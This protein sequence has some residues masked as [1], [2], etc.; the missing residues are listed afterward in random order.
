[1]F[2]QFKRPRDLAIYSV[3]VLAAFGIGGAVF[4]LAGQKFVHWV[5]T[6]KLPEIQRLTQ[7]QF[8]HNESPLSGITTAPA[9]GQDLYGSPGSFNNANWG[10]TGMSDSGAMS[11][12]SSH[13]RRR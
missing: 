4:S 13:R 1:M 10:G 9:F 7:A 8:P 6:D 5:V 11:P 2:G 12:I 3:A